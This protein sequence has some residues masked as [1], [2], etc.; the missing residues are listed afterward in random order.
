MSKIMGQIEPENLDLFALDFGKTAESNF[1]YTVASTNMNQSA[2]NLVKMYVTIRSRMR[3]I[4]D[5]IRPELSELFALELEKL[6]N[7]SLFTPKHLQM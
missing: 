5:L 1:V 6:L 4:M 3:L 7:L 2:P